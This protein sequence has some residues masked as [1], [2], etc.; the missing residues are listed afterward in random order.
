VERSLS[1]LDNL[2]PPDHP[3]RIPVMNLMARI[4]HARGDPERA[5]EVAEQALASGAVAFGGVHPDLAET[6]AVL[7][8]LAAEAGDHEAERLHLDVYNK[9]RTQP[10]E[11]PLVLRR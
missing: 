1:A 3:F 4:E 2:Y 10:R 11:G 5:H 8:A 9:L 6:R 7:A